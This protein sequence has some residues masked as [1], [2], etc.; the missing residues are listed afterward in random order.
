AGIA[1]FEKARAALTA[2][3]EAQD[4]VHPWSRSET[5]V[6][7]GFLPVL[8]TIA[9]PWLRRFIA[10]EPGVDLETR[11][12]TPP[13]RIVELR[14]GRIAAELTFPPPRDPD[15]ASIVVLR[16]PRYVLMAE[17]HPLAAEES[18]EYEQIAG[19]RIPARH[20]S[21]PLEWAQ[22]AWLLNYRGTEPE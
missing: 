6:R 9:R 5:R 16:S 1:F 14:R 3:E 13:E 18:L 15:L 10:A 20:P 2:I 22:E 4:S 8:G 17:A 11:H 21:V 19:E 12:L 7:L